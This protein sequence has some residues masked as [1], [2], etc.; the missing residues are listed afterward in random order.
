MDTK[1]DYFYIQVYGTLERVST[2]DFYTSI[3]TQDTTIYLNG[4]EKTR[5]KYPI[6]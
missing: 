3:L 2:S 5:G 6:K 4:D 1:H